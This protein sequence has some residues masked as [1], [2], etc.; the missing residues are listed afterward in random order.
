MLSEA[1]WRAIEMSFVGKTMGLRRRQNIT[2]TDVECMV[3][4][5]S[6]PGVATAAVNFYR[7]MY[8][9]KE[10]WLLEGLRRPLAMPVL[11]LWG[12]DDGALGKELT[13]NTDRY[14]PK[15]TLKFIPNCSHWVQV[16]AYE[17]VNEALR[18]WLDQQRLVS[19]TSRL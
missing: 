15:L 9:E 18:A 6:L 5:F 8:R 13:D 4:A 2:P 10:A 17:E 16:D 3:H 1:R 19:T 7:N 11:L 14:A 12:E